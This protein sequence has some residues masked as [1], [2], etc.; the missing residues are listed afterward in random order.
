MKI[1]ECEQGTPE[2][3]QARLGR[4]TA[5]NMDRI[6]S[7]T[8]KQSTSVE[9][10]VTQ[11]IA[12]II[13]GESA[14]K[15]QGNI[16]TERGKM[17][18]EEAV[19]Y[20]CMLRKVDAT[21]IGFCTTDDGRIGCSPDRFIGDDGMLEI[22]T[23]LSTIMVDEYEKEILGKGTLEQDHRPQTQC[24]LLVTGRQWVDTVLYSSNMKPLIVRSARNTSYIMDMT[25]FTTEAQKILDRRLAALHGQ[26]F[27]PE[28]PARFLKA[29]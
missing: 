28:D 7:P 21:K 12:E 17:L 26:G 25:R 5:S 13:T 23:C 1:I 20:Y 24:G 14:E 29:G 10:Y 11:I 19:D 15:F 18:E 2:W 16:H 6:I 22:K 4:F 9:K 27:L 3:H 8:G